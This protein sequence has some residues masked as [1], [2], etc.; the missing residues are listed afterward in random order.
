MLTCSLCQRVIR[1]QSR[2]L[3]LPVLIL[4]AEK[5]IGPLRNLA[6]LFWDLQLY[7]CNIIYSRR[8]NY[9]Y[10]QYYGVVKIIAIVVFYYSIFSC[11]FGTYNS[12]FKIYN[13]NSLFYI[14]L[15][16]TSLIVIL[17]SN[18]QIYET[19]HIWY[20]ILLVFGSKLINC[21]FLLLGELKFV[22]K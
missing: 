10:Y 3:L 5:K 8:L 16:P 7:F 17:Y 21:L 4:L 18:Y 15:T 12:N 13:N 6:K 22:Q 20:S 9:I 2:T 11:N 14:N 1:M 19:N